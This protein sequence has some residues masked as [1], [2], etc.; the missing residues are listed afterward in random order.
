MDRQPQ[1]RPLAVL[2]RRR[3]QPDRPRAGLGAARADRRALVD[4]GARVRWPAYRRSLHPHHLDRREWTRRPSLLAGSLATFVLGPLSLRTRRRHRSDPVPVVPGIGDALRLLPRRAAALRIRRALQRGQ[5][6]ARSDI[7]ALDRA[8]L[9]LGSWLPYAYFLLSHPRARTRVGVSAIDRSLLGRALLWGLVAVWAAT[10]VRFAWFH[11]RRRSFGEPKVGVSPRHR[12]TCWIRRSGASAATGN[13]GTTC[14]SPNI[15]LTAPPKRANNSPVHARRRSRIRHGRSQRDAPRAEAHAAS[16]LFDDQEPVRRLQAAGGRQD[17]L[18]GRGRLVRQVLPRARS[19]ECLVASSVEWYLDCALVRGARTRRRRG[20]ASRS[21]KG[22]PFDCGACASH[23]QKV[24]LPVVPITSACNLDCPICYTVNK[25]DGA[26]HLSREEMQTI[27]DHLA[28]DHDELDIINFTGGEPTLHPQLPEFLQM[29]RDAGIRRLT[30]STNGLKLRDEAYVRKLAAL[31][32]RIVLSLDTFRPETDKTLLGA[33]TVKAKLAR[34]TCSRSTTWPRRSCRRSRR[35]S[36]TTRSGRSSSWCSR[37]RTSARSSCTRSRS[38][39]RAA[40]ASSATARITMPDLH[41]RIEEA[42]GGRIDWRT[43]CR[44]RS[45]TR[46]ATRSATCCCLD[47]GG[48]VPFA[49]LISPGDAVRA[50]VGLALHRA[51]REAG[52]GLP[53]H[54]RRAVGRPGRAFP[55]ARAVLATLKRLLERD[56]PAGPRARRSSSASRSPSARRRSTSTRTW[57]RR[58]STS[59]GS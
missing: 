23:Q 45:R 51:A 56:V 50:A 6:R 21:T 35:G 24:Y 48:Y 14:G 33:N 12:V 30:I 49:R 26:H 22:C 11:L 39:A 7:L 44:R 52:G 38:P 36:T 4:L 47:G 42:T 16:L 41:R 31:D 5:Q 34:W 8:T 32:A 43:S 27:L 17:R 57:T 3:A 15:R 18:R 53:R 58:T 28:E 40:S 29:C 37:G 25:N 20:S 59:R 13:C 2:R 55:R 54:D 10:L 1:V 19:A 9:Y 46:T